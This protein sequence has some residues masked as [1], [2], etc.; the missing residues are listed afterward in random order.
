[1]KEIK[2][3][4]SF[5]IPVSLLTDLQ[6]TALKNNS[7]VS[8]VLTYIL[9][10]H[11]KEKEN[12]EYKI[13]T[14]QK[15]GGEYSSKFDKCP[16]CDVKAI[17]EVEK[18]KENKKKKE[19]EETVNEAQAELENAKNNLKKILEHYNKGRATDKEIKKAEKRIEEAKRKYKEVVVK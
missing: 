19:K 8:T 17:K 18:E 5:Y 12:P 15:C 13:L 1:M 14:C 10:N 11:F 6:K 4:T 16:S 7:S 9:R 3:Q 2:T